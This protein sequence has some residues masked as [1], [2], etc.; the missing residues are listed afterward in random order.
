MSGTLR[1]N[2]ARTLAVQMIADGTQAQEAA[3]AMEGESDDELTGEIATLVQRAFTRGYTTGVAV[4]F[5]V[6]NGPDE[7]LDDLQMIPRLAFE[8]DQAR[9]AEQ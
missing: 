8:A 1:R 2:D 6:Q 7:G 9:G 5:T 4:M 3:M